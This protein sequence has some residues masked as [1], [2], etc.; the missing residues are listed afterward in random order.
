MLERL[1]HW[2]PGGGMQPE[3]L[4][5]HPPCLL[6]GQALGNAQV[7]PE[8]PP[9]EFARWQWKRP[10][11]MQRITWEVLKLSELLELGASKLCSP[12][13]LHRANS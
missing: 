13:Y 6:Q 11:V 7:R 10:R 9:H 12:G 3:A 5:T 1:S 4:L 2:A 8:P